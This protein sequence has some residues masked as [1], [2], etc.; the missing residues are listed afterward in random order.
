MRVLAIIAA[1]LICSSIGGISIIPAEEY[2]EKVTA[3][4]LPELACGIVICLEVTR[5]ANYADSN[6]W[7]MTQQLMRQLTEIIEKCEPGY[8]EHSM[9]LCDDISLHHKPP[10]AQVH[11]QCS[12][13][14]GIECS[15]DKSAGHAKFINGSQCM[16]VSFVI[17][18]NNVSVQTWNVISQSIKTLVAKHDN[19]TYQATKHA[20]FN[21]IRLAH[22]NKARTTRSDNSK[23][24]TCDVN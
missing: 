14:D 7:L 9:Q 13:L 5:S 4:K 17:L 23:H 19:S 24:T 10:H 22:K 8:I 21:I 12:L 6:T 2:D 15:R 3:E 18:R 1:C 20:F 16:S 11:L